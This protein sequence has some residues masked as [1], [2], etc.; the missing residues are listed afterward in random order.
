[1]TRVTEEVL[2]VLYLVNFTLG[3]AIF[4]SGI[5]TSNYWASFFG[6]T[7]AAQIRQNT[8]RK[9]SNVHQVNK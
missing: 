5:S 6:V 4:P 7:L 2:H 9:H 8:Y 3:M 1:M